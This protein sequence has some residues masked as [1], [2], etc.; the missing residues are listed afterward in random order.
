M[1]IS[2]IILIAFLFAI[3]LLTSGFVKK[4]RALKLISTVFFTISVVLFL[5]V[6]TLL[7]HM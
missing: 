1:R 3:I 6:W 5:L 4:N 7:S 2:N